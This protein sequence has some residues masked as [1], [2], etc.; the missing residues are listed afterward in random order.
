MTIRIQSNS[1]GFNGIVRQV[2]IELFAHYYLANVKK[3][4]QY[5]QIKETA[6]LF[7]ETTE[8]S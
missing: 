7:Q 5:N 6:R 2:I 8:I 4:E 1:I 3:A